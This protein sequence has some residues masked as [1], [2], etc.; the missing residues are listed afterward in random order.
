MKLFLAAIDRKYVFH[1]RVGPELDHGI[2]DPDNRIM[3]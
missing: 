1:L 2:P 3:I